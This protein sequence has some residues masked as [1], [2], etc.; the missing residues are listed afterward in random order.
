MAYRA[1]FSKT[2]LVSRRGSSS[3]GVFFRVVLIVLFFRT[4]PGGIFGQTHPGGAPDL[5]GFDAKVFAYHFSRADR[6]ITPEGWM[7]EA[8]RG[9]SLA[10]LSWERLALELYGE[11]GLMEAAERRLDEWSE[12]ELEWRFTEWLFKGYFSG[13]MGGLTQNFAAELGETNRRYLFH[14]DGDGRVLY[15]SDTGDPLLIRPGEGDILVDRQQWRQRAAEAVSAGVGEYKSK[16]AE[17]YPELLAYIPDERR[18]GFEHKLE[19][20]ALGAS[21]T[22]Q[23]EFEAI[24]AREERLFLA[25]R[26]GDVFSLR[27]KSDDEAASVIS[28]RLIGETEA[29]CAEGIADLEGRIEAAEGGGGDLALA[30]SEWLAAYREQFERGLK[31]WEE[32][33]ERF[34]IRRIEWEQEA[35]RQYAEGEEAWSVAFV[36]FEQER[37][38]WENKAKTLFESGE[39]L[40]QRASENME[41]AIAEAKAEFEINARIRTETGAERA[42]AWVDMYVTAGSV[43]TGAQENLDFWLERYKAEEAPPPESGELIQWLDSRQNEDWLELQKKFE[44]K[45][46]FSLDNLILG[47]MRARVESEDEADPVDEETY[48]NQLSVLGERFVLWYEI[49]KI[50]AGKSDAA[51]QAEILEKIRERDFYYGS[52][53][54]IGDEI[55]QWANL[56]TTYMEKA[57]EAR[58]A[59]INDFAVVIGTGGLR[60]I[61][62]PG[63]ASEDFNLDEYQIELIRAR[64]VAGY[65]SKRVSVAEAVL[66]YAEEISAGRITDGEGVKAWEG[67]KRAYDDAVVRYEEEQKRLG[68]AGEGIQEARESLNEAAEA[69]QAANNKLEELNQAYGILMAAYSENS[70][71]FILEE[72]ASKYRELLKQQDLL[73]AAGIDGVYMRYLERARELGFAQELEGAGEVLQRLVAGDEGE[74]SLAALRVAVLNINLPGNG[75]AL[76][77]TAEAYGLAPEDPYSALIEQ[78]LDEGH[79]KIAAAADSGEKAAIG[80]RYKDLIGVMLRAAKGRAETLLEN[81]LQG[82]N[83]LLADSAADWYFSAPS[84]EPA[85]GDLEALETE[86]LEERLYQD[87]DRSQR[88]LLSA[89]IDLELEGL[90]HILNGNSTDS[91]AVLLSAFYAADP[92]GTEEFI[93]A[94]DYLREVVKEN[95]HR[96]AG[97]YRD[98]LEKAAAEKDVLRWFLRGGSFF[99]ETWGAKITEGFLPEYTAAKERDEGLLELYRNYGWQI[100]AAAREKWEHSLRDLSRLF[101]SYG[102]ETGG[103]SGLPDITALG[104]AVL[105]RGGNLPENLGV[106]LYQLDEHFNALPEWMKREFD[107]WKSSFI[108]YIAAHRV[109]HEAG[110]G[111]SLQDI[112]AKE[113][114]LQSQLREIQKVYE[115]LDTS[116]PESARALCA[117]LGIDPFITA[118]GQPEKAGGGEDVWR[119]L[120]SYELNNYYQKLFR[121]LQQLGYEYALVKGYEEIHDQATEAEQEGENHWRQYITEG[122]LSDYNDGKDGE[123]EKLPAGITGASGED[124]RILKGALNQREGILA[125]ALV[126]AERKRQILN[127]ALALYNEK[128]SSP[129]MDS[130]RAKVRAYRNNASLDWDASAIISVPYRYYDNY[131]LEAGE[132]RKHI[133]QEEYLRLEIGRLGMG[134][135]IA[136]KGETAILAEKEKRLAAIGRQQ[137]EYAK[138][139][140][141]YAEA[142]EAFLSLGKSYDAIYEKTKERYEALENARFRYETQDAIRRW[143]STAYLDPGKGSAYTAEP[144][145]A[146]YD[147]LVYSRERRDRAKIVLEVLAG[148]YDNGE[149]RRPYADADYEA[150]YKQYEESFGRMILSLRALDSIDTMIGKEAQ[151]NDAYYQ[152]YRSYLDEWG[153]LPEIDGSYTSPE[154]KNQWSVMDLISLRDGKLAFARDGVF[155][156]SGISGEKAA[157]LEEYFK[158]DKSIGTETNKSSLFEEALRG[159]SE[160]MAGYNF[161]SQKYKQWGLA[162]DYLI[163][164][165]ISQGTDLEFLDSLYERAKALERGQNLGEMPI[166]PTPI[167]SHFVK[168]HEVMPIYN[169]ILGLSQEEAWTNLSQ[170]ERED[171]EFYTILT[172]LGKGGTNSGAF[173]QISELELFRF[174]FE[175]ATAVYNESR[176]KAQKALTGWIYRS[177]RD[178]LE[179]T[180]DRLKP[181][182]DLLKRNVSGGLAGM[183][184]LTGNLKNA[185]NAY[186]ESCDH[187]AALLGEDQEK[188]GVIWDDLLQA[189]KEA[190]GLSGEEL[191]KLGVY[192]NLMN[193]DMEGMYKNNLEALRA[194]VQWSRSA[195]EDIKRDFEQAWVED[196]EFRQ[197]EELRYRERADAYVSAGGDPERLAP[198]DAFGSEAA[199][200]KNH[201]ENLERVI[202]GD[203][204]GV[205]EHGS[206][207]PGEYIELAGEY[208]DLITRAYAMRYAAELAAR[209]AE[210]AQQR[211]DVLEKY[212]A[213]QRTAELILERGREDWKSGTVKLQD[214]YAQ[215][216][217]K[218]QEEF[219]RVNNLWTVSYLAGLEDKETWI[220]RASEAANSASSGAVLALVGADAELMARAMDTRL[221]ADMTELGGAEAAR[222]KL[223]ELLES[224]GI[225][226]LAAAFNG[227]NGTAETL[228]AHLKRGIGGPFLWNTGTIRTA[229]AAF[230]KE[231]NGILADREAKK[232][233]AHVREI[234]QEAVKSLG[235]RVDKANQ[236][237]RDSMDNMFV[238]EGQWKR[239]G[240]NYI[241]DVIVHSTLIDPVIT[242]Q[243]S[244]EGYKDYRMEP[245][246]LKT[247]LSENRLK[248]LE[249][250]TVQALIEDMFNELSLVN[251]EIFGTAEENSR[252]GEKARTVTIE[253]YGEKTR[254]IY[255]TVIVTGENGDRTEQ[256]LRVPETYMALVKS[257]DRTTGAGKFGLHIGYHP[258]IKTGISA[259]QGKDEIFVNQ[260][261]GQLGK[262]MADYIYWNI[263][264]GKGISAM[265]MAAWDKP[266]WD[267]R[268]SWFNAPSVR[269]VVD[270]GNKIAAVAAAAVLTPVTGGASMAAMAAAVST[271][272]NLSDDLIFGLMDVSG[273]YKTLGEAGFDFGKKALVSAAASVMTPVFSGFNGIATGGLTG[274]SKVI[275]QPAV[276]GIQAVSTGTVTGALNAFTYDRERGF[277]WST[278]L[279]AQGMRGA[280]V[281]ALVD[282]TGTFTGGI[283]GELDLFDGNYNPLAGNIFNRE[284]IGAFNDLAGG[285]ARQGVS[286]A[287]GQD[288]TL[289]L[290]NAG[291]LTGGKAKLGLLELRLG[292][293]G[294]AMELGSNGADLGPAALM[295]AAGGLYDVSKIGGAKLAS[296]FG[297]DTPLSTLNAVNMLGYTGNTVNETIGRDI[298]ENKIKVVYGALGAGEGGDEIIGKYDHES[299]G[300]MNLSEMLLGKGNDRAIKLATVMAHEGLHL[301]GNRYESAAYLQSL[302]TYGSL[303]N[304]L[305]AEGDAGFLN[306]MIREIY[307]PA[308]YRAN[309]GSVDYWILTHNG[310]LVNDNQGYLKDENDLYINRDGSRT[311]GIIPGQTIGA[312]G[313][314]TGLLNI[315]YGGTGDVGYGNFSD[316]Q[317]A[318]V[319]ELLYQSGFIHDGAEDPRDRLWNTGNDHRV[320]PFYALLESF[321]NTMSAQVFMNGMDKQSDNAAFGSI[322]DQRKAYKGI[323]GY[324]TERFVRLV[325]AKK[326]FYDGAQALFQS[327]D[328]LFISQFFAPDDFYAGGQ[329]RGLDVGGAPET[330]ILSGFS[331]RVAQNYHS[332]S[333]GNS[334]VVEYGFNFEDS[335]YTTGIQAQFMHLKYPSSLVKD[336]F[337]TDTQTIGFMGNTGLVVPVP[338]EKNPDAG[339]HLHYQLMGNLA[340]YG[341]EDRAWSPFENRRNRFLS[342]IGAPPSSKYVIDRGDSY[343]NNYTGMG[344]D[345]YFYNPNN[346]GL[347][348]GIPSA[349]KR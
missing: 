339:T 59:L 321:G 152:T 116:G 142:A 42:K 127:S 236:G 235:E 72:F 190:G 34:F 336:T 181:S 73:N 153:R 259:A 32:A 25:R 169:H 63:A 254:Y 184:T 12:S 131:Y 122:F 79:K 232:I 39:R 246:V 151:K 225:A 172:I 280:A 328:G 189:L 272:I 305:N 294:A 68:A 140:G 211:R 165:L 327:M 196:E 26:V 213:W 149:T 342:Q 31:A 167:F 21:F 286:Y 335:F 124:Y 323:P 208:V 287:L 105:N 258:V 217:K 234:S 290:L 67:A 170:Q 98:K 201:L 29:I 154:D 35:G 229:A 302:G 337:I 46:F 113:G 83:L 188:E 129:D 33:E 19:Q 226:N 3:P 257:E 4:C 237:F 334:L 315:L 130:F 194:L 192:W 55:R 179:V 133:A 87:A 274:L 47:S 54:Q 252:E 219:L 256:Q 106:F 233:A 251:D 267:S 249:A 279:F 148:L 150:L 166:H 107:A 297:S 22:I 52:A 94:L 81:R 347:R 205:M 304:Q 344:Y 341:A 322:D 330:P 216:T 278:D 155:D 282:M 114:A 238:V 180:V 291:L 51:R 93:G 144:Y 307:N 316:D 320:I 126:E 61:L 5:P 283:L 186:K 111:K 43:V 331:G 14:T 281:N 239:Q 349:G 121:S 343:L 58:D 160:R 271:T 100:P 250:F 104:G 248:D 99:H 298:W 96:D 77:G 293:G 138:V 147:D 11:P 53:L 319:Q 326:S 20:S 253:E 28:A 314:E 273:G 103:L 193:Q 156:F 84:H 269:G 284:K 268:N 310:F 163:R 139:S 311:A 60:D 48:L 255:K 318:A 112:Q 137:E 45:G 101:D 292:S 308:S 88:A 260:G 299:P 289:N 214:A 119:E 312:R 171:L 136:K 222:N 10:R 183:N 270:M 85:Q 82:L 247:D 146:P 245:V 191:E 161:D 300:T 6:E 143:A 86:G 50:I 162:R 262:L 65:W 108:A 309:P 182:L 277:G 209:E 243:T 345:N 75:E 175:D 176:Q 37:Q 261:T 16:L 295:A 333:A 102:I 123:D 215:W 329:H 109:Y 306:M 198:A 70:V 44:K 338:G 125:D 36:R 40:F 7:N 145:K 164:Q 120:L 27:R 17:F 115:A 71:D 76:A 202:L 230:A 187:I 9:I 266:M 92:E 324:M 66:A 264:E 263:Q 325:E 346:L 199:A 227:I 168:I 159:L 220:V 313:V 141:E 24:A 317:I 223:T 244:V 231:T 185:Y 38:N 224:A 132:L 2:A 117:A 74:P 276:T 56:Y 13:F 49:E 228:S 118:L 134:Y 62:D 200:G 173:S 78:L 206:G 240:K 15:D 241:K 207:Y 332:A 158:E 41:R 218:Y 348:M 210:W 174:A 80:E 1:S 212:K 8:R 177:D 128:E 89:R 204:D 97:T 195:K 95:I 301:M 221:P 110:P 285:L 157:I 340:G 135:D 275:T 288:F 69:L 296:L 242:E 64:A 197:K 23:R 178:M 90:N 91:R 203:L 57:L 303:I 265:S 30:G 18:A